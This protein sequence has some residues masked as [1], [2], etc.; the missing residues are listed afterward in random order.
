MCGSTG[1]SL[2]LTKSQPG[3]VT[4]KLTLMVG[5]GAGPVAIRRPV[6]QAMSGVQKGVQFTSYAG[7]AGP[8]TPVGTGQNSEDAPAGLNACIQALCSLL[9]L[10]RRCGASSE[11]MS[12]RRGLALSG[13][14]GT[15]QASLTFSHRGLL[16]S[17]HQ[18]PHT[19]HVGVVYDMTHRPTIAGWLHAHNPANPRHLAR[20]GAVL[21]HPSAMK[22]SSRKSTP[23][24]ELY[25]WSGA[26]LHDSKSCGC[27]I[28]QDKGH[29]HHG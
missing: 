18:A 29:E 9:P 26:T 23:R 6:D 7:T 28:D 11:P 21:Q 8:G 20:L 22:Q 12:T 19:L 13:S 10:I 14:V 16:R 24:G 4:Q 2:G 17:E 15:W 25:E 1:H 27:L 5:T 3:A